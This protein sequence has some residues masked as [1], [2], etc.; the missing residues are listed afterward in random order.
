LA[1]KRKTNKP[2]ALEKKMCVFSPLYYE[3]SE[4]KRGRL[5]LQCLL[6]YNGSELTA[7]QVRVGGA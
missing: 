3:N 1:K 5:V 7:F 6:F 2:E 4:G